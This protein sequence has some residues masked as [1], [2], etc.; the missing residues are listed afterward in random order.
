M[1]TIRPTTLPV[2]FVAL[3]PGAFLDQVA[4]MAG[5]PVDKGRLTWIGKSTVPPSPAPSCR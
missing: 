4:S 1:T 3:R 5:D 2:P